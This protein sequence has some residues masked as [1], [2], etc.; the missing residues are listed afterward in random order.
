MRK[1]VVGLIILSLITVGVAYT[2]TKQSDTEIQPLSINNVKGFRTTS[3]VLNT[4]LPKVSKKLMVYECAEPNV[5]PEYVSLLAKRFGMNGQPEKVFDEF[6]L[7]DGNYHLEVNTKSGRIAY[8]DVS[9]WMVGNNVDK[10]S[11]LPSDKEAIKIARNYLSEKGLMPTDAILRDVTHPRVV[12][13]DREGNVIGV[14]FED[15]KVSFTRKINGLPVVGAGSKLDVE[16][17]GNGDVI[18]VYKVWRNYR[19]YKEY[20][21]ITPEQ[22][23]EKLK[24]I[25]I[26]TGIKSVDK[27]VINKVYLGYYTKSASEKQTYLQP[28]YVF[29][30]CA[31]GENRTEEFKQYIPAIPELGGI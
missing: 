28:V 5:T 30:G 9:R 27:A 10:P 8:T 22:A 20:S 29:E 3:F 12:A 24:E 14:G 4:T 11:N 25:G 1:L 2:M 16:V 31:E 21:I 19:P 6:L 26:F 17:G 18:N 15:V 23:L 13:M 7:T